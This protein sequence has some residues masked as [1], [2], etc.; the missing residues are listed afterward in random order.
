M[1]NLKALYES[2][3]KVGFKPANLSKKIAN[4]DFVRLEELRQS[5]DD[6]LASQNESDDL[7]SHRFTFTLGSS[8]SGGPHPCSNPE[9]RLNSIKET[10]SFASAYA[11]KIYLPNFFHNYSFAAA[12]GDHL[13]DLKMSFIADILVYYHV[14]PLVERGMVEV[15]SSGVNICPECYEKRCNQINNLILSQVGN[16]ITIKLEEDGVIHF[17]D[18]SQLLDG[19]FI[20]VQG[21]SADRFHHLK[22]PHVFSKEE[23]VKYKILN[24]ASSRVLFDITNYK[25][26]GASGKSSYLTSRPLDA[27]VIKLLMPEIENAQDQ[28]MTGTE[29]TIP[30][31]RGADMSDILHM[32]DSEQEAFDVYR[33]SVSKLIQSDLVK[34]A[35]HSKEMLDDI[36]KPKLDKLTLKVKKHKEIINKR[37]GR[38]LIINMTI[39][40]L[41]LLSS[42]FFNLSDN[43]LH[44]ATLPATGLN[45]ASITS[46]IA[47]RRILPE[48][49]QTSEFFF[50]WKLRQSLH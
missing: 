8:L 32:R 50:L 39:L 28:I 13:D 46:D 31:I 37:I 36:V 1:N 42:K 26:N 22:V 34:N 43:I 19:N 7:V 15:V 17:Y 6:L 12:K 18:N 23:I 4:L 49:V 29:H 33:N 16:D 48:E 10:A 30:F 20:Y 14:K 44:M 41:G 2:L 11:D 9:C 40:S 3:Q 45:V 47:E 35:K 24:H 27:K 5:F 38:K 25:A 21:A